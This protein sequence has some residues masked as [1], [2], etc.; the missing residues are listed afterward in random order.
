MDIFVSNEWGF[1]VLGSVAF[2]VL[3]SPGPAD[4]AR[5]VDPCLVKI[6]DSFALLKQWQHRQ[7]ILLPK[8]ERPV[9][10]RVVRELLGLDIA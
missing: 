7:G 9:R 5:L 3:C 1:G 10:V 2:S 4:E 8:H 6:Y